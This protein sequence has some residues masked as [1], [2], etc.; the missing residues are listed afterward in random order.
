MESLGSLP[1]RRRS[2]SGGASRP[3]TAARGRPADVT[4][5]IDNRTQFTSSRFLD[6]LGQLGITH[7]R[8]VVITRNATATWNGFIA[9]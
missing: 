4:L 8:T 7:R 9:A 2:D 6:A 3:T 1:D 5:T